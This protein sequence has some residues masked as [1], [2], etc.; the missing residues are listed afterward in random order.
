[1]CSHF[2]FFWNVPFKA[3]HGSC[4]KWLL[5]AMCED[6]IQIFIGQEAGCSFKPI[7]LTNKIFYF[8]CLQENTKDYRDIPVGK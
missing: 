1:M 7:V 2:L 8:V 6:S 5:V 3:V 4:L